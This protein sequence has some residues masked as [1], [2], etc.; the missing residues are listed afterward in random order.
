M[1]GKYSKQSSL[2]KSFSFRKRSQSDNLNVIRSSTKLNSKH[3]SFSNRSKTKWPV[4]NVKSAFLPEF[5]YH[6]DKLALDYEPLELIAK[7]CY[8]CVMKAQRKAD[9][10]TVAIKMINKSRV[11]TEGPSSVQQ[12]K[13]EVAIQNFAC[14]ERCPFICEIHTFWQTRTMLYI[15]LEY[16]PGGELFS[17]WKRCGAFSESLTRFFLGE[18]ALTLEFFH[19]KKVLYRDLKL[20]NIM[21]DAQGHVKLIDFGLSKMLP[22]GR[23]RTNTICGTLQYSA[24]EMLEGRA[25]N[26]AA[27]WWSFGILMFA[28]LTGR[29]PLEGA[30]DHVQMGAWIKGHTYQLPD[31]FTDEART[32]CAQLLQ[33]NPLN[34][35]VGIQAVQRSPFFRGALDL[36]ALLSK[37][38][39]PRDF[40]TP[41]DESIL[42]ALSGGQQPHA[43]LPSPCAVTIPSDEFENF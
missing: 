5:P 1:G 33:K 36:Q 20:E 8:G 11:M 16:V 10:C 35:L 40:I 30:R 29:F 38:C 18:I 19:S 28:L 26:R 13:D 41:D 27:D 23:E 15:V 4:S 37:Q 42:S 43:K 24:P 12:C 34:R 2:G 31:K 6:D 9:L 39:H 21:L 14:L 7:G 22:P 3:D 32:T 17:I 25:Y